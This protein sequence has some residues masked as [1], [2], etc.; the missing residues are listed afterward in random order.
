M[1]ILHE[2][3]NYLSVHCISLVS[4]SHTWT[5]VHSLKPH[6]RSKLC[7]SFHMVIQLVGTS[8]CLSRG[9]DTTQPFSNPFQTVTFLTQPNPIHRLT[10]PCT[11][12][13]G[14]LSCSPPFLFFVVLQCRLTRY[15]PLLCLK[16]A[17]MCHIIFTLCAVYKQ[18]KSAL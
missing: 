5:W 1:A 6:P 17:K 7:H 15:D 10:Q 4:S 8:I 13:M 12:V 11:S 18:T 2:A 14:I 9:P 3:S 16:V